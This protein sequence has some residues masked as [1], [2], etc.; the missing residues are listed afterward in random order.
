MLADLEELVTCESYSADHAAVA[1]SARVVA[2][3]GGRLLGARPQTLVSGGV[4]HL[5]WSFGTPR[6]LLL[7]HHDTVWPLGTLTTHPFSVEQGV[8]RG[9]GVFDM[10]A[11]L[12]QMFHALAGLPSLDGVCVLVTGDEEVGSDT[13]RALI[14][15]TARAC[16]AALVL[17]ASVAGALKT[18]RKGV[19]HYDLTVHG[20][21]A[22][23]GLEPEKGVN[24]ATELA[25]HLLALQDITDTVN[26]RTGP[27]TTITPT[28]L[29]A[30]TTTNTVPAR[31]DLSLDVR[32]PSPAAQE[33]VDDLVRGLAPRHPEARLVVGG[34]PNR[35]PLDAAS[36][37]SLFALACDTA[38][39]IG[40][41]PLRQ[42]SVGGASDGNYTAG[43]GCPTLDG[44]G[45]V[46]DGAHAD[47]EH[48]IIADM[49][50]R[51]HLLSHLVGALL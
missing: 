21:A 36:S 15:D 50:T 17:E 23:S 37:Q 32:V 9:P 4:T 26:A 49:P 1:R 31:A 24:A 28:V 20:R 44:L 5:R 18:R 29:S 42:A 45:A 2:D 39:R 34:G 51:A 47:H 7:G 6:V 40:L 43:V 3:Q 12:V 16:R 14:E 38:D 30:G 11:G 41:G 8:A 19:S 22:H 27:G 10:K 33:A 13:S 48:V 25:H 35:P 46:G